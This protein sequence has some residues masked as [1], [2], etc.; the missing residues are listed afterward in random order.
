MNKLESVSGEA[1]PVTWFKR[2]EGTKEKKIGKD[3]RIEII[4][5]NRKLFL[6]INDAVPEDSG[7][8]S[9]TIGDLRTQARLTVNEIPL[10]FKSPLKDQKAREGESA[11]FE[12]TVN[13]GDKP[14]KWLVNGEPV[15]N[16]KSGKY[17]ASQ[18]RTTFSFTINDLDLLNDDEAVISCLVGDKLKSK[19]KLRVIEDDIRLV[20]RLVDVGAKETTTVQFQCKLNK[21]KYRNRPN[22]PLNV[23]W[24]IKGEEIQGD[25]RFVSGQEDTLLTLEIKSV[26]YQD[27]GVVKCKINN[28]ITTS[29]KLSVEEEPVV[30][31]QK[32]TDVKCTKI[33]GQAIFECML[34]KPFS[35]VVWFKNG[36][37]LPR[38]EKY[39][40]AQ[41]RKVHTLTVNDVDGKDIGEYTILLQGKYEKTC[42]STLSVRSA[43]TIHLSKEYNDGVVIKRGQP[44]E[45]NVNYLGYPVPTATW[46][47]HEKELADD[48]RTKIEIIKNAQA[49]LLVTKTTLNDSG[50]YVLILENECGR[51]KCTINVKVLDRPGPPRNLDISNI[52]G[53]FLS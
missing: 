26:S 42:S 10:V 13:R 8:Y 24:F 45:L 29:A 39:V 32:L 49:T 48:N 25:P 31:V 51:D 43:P 36:I 14:V 50:K 34:N 23:K 28:S 17:T 1:Y 16:T 4:S 46:F 18:G 40:A 19:A 41:D 9:V 37:E 30:F 44:L 47:V 52:S 33:P 38:N 15:N 22:E 20:E 6:K 53:R 11:T 7:H 3:E 35:E 12:F 27:A 2:T 21:T 5:K